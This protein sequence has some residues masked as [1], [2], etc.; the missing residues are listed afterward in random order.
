MTHRSSIRLKKV[1]IKFNDIIHELSNKDMSIMDM[2][3]D[4][5]LHAGENDKVQVG[6]NDASFEMSNGGD[7]AEFNTI[8][9][10]LKALDEGYSS[11]NYVRKFLRAL[12]PKWRAKV[13][14]IEE[15]KDLT[16]LSL[17]E[18]IGN[19]K[20]HEMI[21]QKD[22][23]IVKAKVER[24]SLSLKA[25][26]ESSNEECSNSR[27][28]DEEYV[29]AVEVL[30]R[31]VGN[32]PKEQICLATI[33]ENSALWH[34]RLGHAN[35]RHI[36]SLTSKELVR[37]LPKLNLDK[38]FYD[39]CKIR[40][41]AHSSHKAKN[42]VSITRCI[43]LLHMKLFGPFAVRSYRENR[44][45]LV[46]VNYYSGYTWTRFLKDKIEAFD[47]IE[48]FSKKIQNQLG[49]TTVSIRTD[50][51]REFDNEV[52]FGEFCNANGITHNIS[53]PRTPQS[54][55]VVERKNRTL[56][57]LS[58]TIAILGKTPYE[59]LRGVK[60]TLEYFRV[61]GS[62]CF[63]L[64]TKDYLTKFDS[65]SYEDETPPPSKTSPLVDDDLDEEEAIKVNEK[66]NLEKNIEDETLEIDEVFNTKESKNHPLE[67]FIGNLNQRTLRPRTQEEKEK[68]NVPADKE[69]YVEVRN[70]RNTNGNG[71][72]FN[73]KHGYQGSKIN[74]RNNNVKFMFRPKILTGPVNKGKQVNS[75]N[76][77]GSE[78]VRKSNEELMIDRRLIVDEFVKSKLQPFIS[79]TKDWSYDMINYFKYTWEALKR[80][81]NEK[82][83]EEDVMENTDVVQSIIANKISKQFI[84]CLVETIPDKIKFYV[85]FVYASNNRIE[86]REVRNYLVMDKR[87]CGNHPWVI[88]GDII[89]YKLSKEDAEAMI[90][91]AFDKKIKKA[92]FDIDSSKVSGPD[93]YTLF[94][95]KA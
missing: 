19:L 1:P 88:I 73:G 27:N 37:N 89:Q 23:E 82:C 79:D 25:R 9:T 16:S 34:R 53:A 66:K 44:Y 40:K 46:I 55:G 84:L 52:Q 24:K 76:Q 93:G 50:Y 65:K 85:N 64:N 57:E 74:A 38:H 61:F 14:V 87:I 94:F 47:Q 83:N 91:E 81:M 63:I 68:T 15:P 29:M 21:I 86:R 4:N 7:R 62:K 5:T 72:N 12:H 33:N 39:T 71:G 92:M 30:G 75:D 48:I 56:P 11:K 45:T 59:L 32:K 31:K 3:D 36:Q 13:K 58:R 90:V 78:I 28:E 43:E 6:D 10:S 35:M 42:I 18:L 8:I 26:K 20:V 80:R 77:K 67:N 70:G 49:C 51:G 60:Y 95:Q 54:N 2:L 17:D 69:R 41:Q 22:S